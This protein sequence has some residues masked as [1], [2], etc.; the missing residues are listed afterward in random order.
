MSD[1]INYETQC[2]CVDAQAAGSPC[3]GVLGGPCC[4]SSPKRISDLE[5]R[6]AHLE[7]LAAKFV[8][9]ESHGESYPPSPER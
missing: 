5:R 8:W 6:N 9:E 3:D 2:Y 7:A 4:V 1:A